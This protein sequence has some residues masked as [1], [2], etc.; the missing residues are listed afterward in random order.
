[1][2]KLGN[3][4]VLRNGVAALVGALLLHCVASAQS[5][6]RVMLQEHRRSELDLQVAGELAGV[7]EGATRFISR[8]ELLK[9]PQV[10]YRVSDDANFKA[11]VEISGVLLEELSK[12]IASPGAGEM[13]VAICVDQYR[14]NY[15]PDYVRAHHPVLVLKING[16]PPA[17]WPKDAAGR[18]PYLGPY[19]ISHAKFTPSFNIL[20]HAD[21]P[22]IPWGVVKLEFRN[23]QKV[24]AAIAPEG[25]NAGNASVQA[26]FQI[27]RQNCFRCHNMG[28]EG[29]KKS[30]RPWLVLA[31]W[32]TTN[33]EH[34]TSYVRNPKA[35]N[36]N[37]Q[38]AASPQYD[39]ETMKTLV[40]YFKTFIA[41]EK[42]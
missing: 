31:A 36:P 29:G 10:T 26:G 11:R 28:G 23:E 33:P 20:A 35:N 13:V 22:Q 1:M 6:G 7:S 5:G 25:P 21:E 9:L 34:F 16:K 8:E 30:G 27:A 12:A 41:R 4:R 24:F 17:A 18:A 2:L 40:E 37:T 32:A 19:L 42:R 3:K 38:M 14:G 15:P 39:D